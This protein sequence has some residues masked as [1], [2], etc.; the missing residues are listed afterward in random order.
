MYRRLFF[1]LPDEAHTMQVVHDI[2]ASGIDR[3][4]I[5][6]VPGHGVTLTQLPTATP[7]QQH[8]AAGRIE[9]M[10]WIT[11]LVIFFIALT[12]L[13]QTLA[14]NSVP[15]TVVAL[16]V[17]AATVIA[18]VLFASLVPDTHLG[19]L[20]SALSHGD[21]VLMMDV[22]KTRVREIEGVAERH[23]PEVTV[24]GVGWTIGALGI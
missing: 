13:I 3:S 7:R 2:E 15:W 23:H 12:G 8:D 24:G 9:K 19:D 10:A 16:L 11:N 18:G 20:H 22:P 1:V 4:H 17:A 5:H 14:R 6:A 21:I